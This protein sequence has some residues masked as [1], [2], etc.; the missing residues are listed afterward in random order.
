M[1]QTKH[2]AVA[3]LL[4]LAVSVPGFSGEVTQKFIAS[5]A[6][7]KT[8]GYR[9]I[10]AVMDL[11][12][13]AIGVAPEDLQNPKYGQFE[14]GDQS[15]LF[16]LDEPEDGEPKMFIDRNGDGDLTNDTEVAWEGRK[17]GEFTTYYG[18][19]EIE[20][21]NGEVAAMSMYR[22]DPG[23]ERRKS[24][25]NTVLYYGDFGFQI[26]LELDGNAF[27][28]F[29][30]GYITEQS[31]LQIDRNRDGKLS[32]NFESLSIGEPF[33]F[34]GTTYELKLDKGSLV[35]A[36][37]EEA[38]P[39]LPLPPDL[40]IGKPAL[41]FTAKTMAGDEI[42]FPKSYAGKLV[43]LD[44]WAT[45]CGPCIREIP[46]MKVAYESWHDKGFEILGISFDRE[47]MEEKL[48]EFLEEKELPWAQIYEGKGWDTT[49][50]DMHDVSGIP[51]VLLVDGDS[52]EILATAKEL[53]GEGLSEFIGEKIAEKFG[54]DSAE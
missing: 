33:N 51:F 38:I 19:A 25:A 47:N 11:E 15:W 7:E 24:L 54:E 23:D 35:L 45:W 13:D 42:N 53:R 39:Q 5:G 50:G 18:D 49:L 4:S 32:R 41:E 29:V 14:F 22:F 46:N 28:T 34:T 20:F 52:G 6:T 36:E 2:T 8:G 27:E 21:E 3:A 16:I 40:R 10:R 37:A 31:R 43:M 12:S 44:F 9:P 17:Q 30:S 1:I 48:L 26:D